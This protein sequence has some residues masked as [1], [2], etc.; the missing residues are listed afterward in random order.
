MFKNNR[1]FSREKLLDNSRDVVARFSY[2]RIGKSDGA[3][4]LQSIK[5]ENSESKSTFSSK[6][7]LEVL[8]LS[9]NA[10]KVSLS[11][12][13]IVRFGIAFLQIS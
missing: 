6:S 3:R 5:I 13:I 10:I 9:I 2:T 8:F 4:K 7:K 12:S 11:F 1:E